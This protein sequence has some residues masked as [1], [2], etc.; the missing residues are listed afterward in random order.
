MPFQPYLNF[1][2]NCRDVFERYHQIFGGE[3]TILT[4][5]DM[6]GDAVPADQKDLVMHAALVLGDGNVLM[7]S[8]SAEFQG[9]R[10]MYVN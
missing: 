7:A 6:P 1:G 5:A 2:G 10:D 3:V 8:D 4:M 9:A